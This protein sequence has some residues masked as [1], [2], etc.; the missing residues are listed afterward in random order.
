MDGSDNNY[1]TKHRLVKNI[2]VHSRYLLETFAN[3]ATDIIG[4]VLPVAGRCH[5]RIERF[6]TPLAYIREL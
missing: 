4:M 3:F 5:R 1:N 6:R 2:H